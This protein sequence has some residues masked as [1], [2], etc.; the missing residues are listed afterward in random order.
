MFNLI[1]ILYAYI[2]IHVHIS[3]MQAPKEKISAANADITAKVDSQAAWPTVCEIIF[4]L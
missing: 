3:A 2:Y 1:S 4:S